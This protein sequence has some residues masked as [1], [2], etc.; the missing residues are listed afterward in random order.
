MPDRGQDYVLPRPGTAPE[1]E[2]AKPIAAPSEVAFTSAFGALL[3]P[4]TYLKTEHGTTAYYDLPPTA[5][6]P[7]TTTNSLPRVLVIHGI[8]TPALGL[9]PLVT[10]L[11]ASRP[12]THFV[13]YDHW[14]HGLSDTPR[15][16]HT[17][18]LF[19]AQLRALLTHLHWSDA[20]FVGYSFG[21]ATAAGYAATFPEA[22]KSLVLLAPAGMLPEEGFSERERALIRGGDGVDEGESRDWILDFL[23]GGKLVVPSGWEKKVAAGGVVAEAVRDWERKEH[24]GHVP[25]VVAIF[26]DGGV[27]GRHADFMLAA[28]NVKKSLAVLGELDDVCSEQDMVNV[29]V[30]NVV[31]IPE[32]GHALVRERVPEVAGLI[33]TFWADL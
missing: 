18:P 23:E 1:Q 15:A 31:V 2:P 6:A 7:L 3:P 28:Q 12:H 20:H 24:E 10:T 21:G 5:A 33:E 30:K 13:L 26:R 11:Q 25:S 8:C 32:A 16:P 29:G 22:V 9:Q 4:V 27:F 19:Y 17:P 14:G